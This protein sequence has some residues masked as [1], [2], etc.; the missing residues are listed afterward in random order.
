MDRLIRTEGSLL[1]VFALWGVMPVPH[2]AES[3]SIIPLQ[4]PPRGKE[5]TAVFAGHMDL[6]QPS[7]LVMKKRW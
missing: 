7:S 1:G 2:M 3:W 6:D 4:H 5:G